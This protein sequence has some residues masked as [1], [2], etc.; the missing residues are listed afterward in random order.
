MTSN[1]EKFLLRFVLR[2]TQREH[3]RDIY[4]MAEQIRRRIVTVMHATSCMLCKF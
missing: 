4:D 3:E 2:E 1:L